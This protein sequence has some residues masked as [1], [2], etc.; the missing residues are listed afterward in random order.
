ML[1]KRA[2]EEIVQSE[3]EMRGLLESLLLKIK[4]LEERRR[5]LLLS[6][7]EAS[8]YNSVLV[9]F[10]VE[11][12][13][14]LHAFSVSVFR[15]EEALFFLTNGALCNDQLLKKP[16]FLVKVRDD[17]EDDLSFSSSSSDS[18]NESSLSDNEYDESSSDENL[19]N[20]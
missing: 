4:I 13:K 15:R 6:T 11:R 7:D 5:I 2:E 1:W 14:S 16:L 19:S 17:E 20:E 3:N 10:E 8:D 9:G 18:S 12:L